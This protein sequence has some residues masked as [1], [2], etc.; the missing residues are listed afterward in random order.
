MNLSAVDE[1]GREGRGLRSNGEWG[2]V[3]SGHADS[4][5]RFNSVFVQIWKG[6]DQIELFFG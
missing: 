6:F 3:H 1:A 5:A 4:V 2:G